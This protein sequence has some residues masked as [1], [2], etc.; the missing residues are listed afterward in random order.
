MS[1]ISS[2]EV[3]NL[4]KNV[5]G[6][7][8]DILPK[9]ALLAKK[10]PFVNGQKVGSKF[11]EAIVLSHETGVTFGGSSMDAF[12]IEPANAGA[13]KQAEIEPSSIVLPSIIPFGVI[14]RT[15]GGGEKAFYAATKHVIKNNLRSHTKFL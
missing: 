9:D 5:Y 14:S 15:A 13:V 4:F 7:L 11:V 1:Q 10:I 2:A 3:V 8:Q 6:D 12:E